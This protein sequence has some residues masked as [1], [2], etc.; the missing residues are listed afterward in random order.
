MNCS[1]CGNRIHAGR[2]IYKC[3]CGSFTHTQCWAKHLVMEH[4]PQY[5]LGTLTLDEEFV[6]QEA[7]APEE[8]APEEQAPEE[9]TPEETIQT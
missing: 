1:V 2:A 7:E 9:E 4:Q 3:S 6:P 5:V 8:Q